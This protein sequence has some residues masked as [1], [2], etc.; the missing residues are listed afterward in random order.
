VLEA[1]HIHIYLFNWP[2]TEDKLWY[3]QPEKKN[4]SLTPM[5]WVQFIVSVV[6]GL[7]SRVE[8][9]QL[10]SLIFLRFII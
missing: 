2:Y 1:E 9:V 4:P 8:L 6:I 5:D 10:D 7:V 3:L